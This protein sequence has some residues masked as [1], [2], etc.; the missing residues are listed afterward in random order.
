[1]AANR[2]NTHRPLR[3]CR[4]RLSRRLLR[5]KNAEDTVLERSRNSEPCRVPSV[6]SPINQ[7]DK[8]EN[9]WPR[10]PFAQQA[11][12]EFAAL[13]VEKQKIAGRT[14]EKDRPPH[15]GKRLEEVIQHSKWP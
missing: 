4:F 8:K 15:G 5:G 12:T 3:T 13:I 1:M 2:A 7:G 9:Q 11:Q 10:I 14:D 6:G